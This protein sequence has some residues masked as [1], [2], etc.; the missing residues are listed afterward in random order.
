MN[1]RIVASDE[2][3]KLSFQMSHAHP[4]G[5]N[6]IACIFY[7]FSSRVDPWQPRHLLVCAGQDVSDCTGIKRTR[8]SHIYL[9]HNLSPRRNSAA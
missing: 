7:F 3:D 4:A 6:H 9:G 5:L 1:L 8:R 2:T